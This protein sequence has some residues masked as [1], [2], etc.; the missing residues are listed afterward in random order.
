MLNS[1]RCLVV[2]LLGYRYKRYGFAWQSLFIKNMTKLISRLS[3][4]NELGCILFACI[5]YLSL[6][7]ARGEDSVSSKFQSYQED[8]GRIEVKALYLRAEK[9]LDE[10]TSLGVTALVDDITGATP[11]G[12]PAPVGSDQ[13]PLSTLTEHR[14][15]IIGDISRKWND[16]DTFGFEFAYSTESDYIS[17]GYS[18]RSNSEFNKKNTS[19]N[20][21]YSFID[22]DIAVGYQDDDEQ[23]FYS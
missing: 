5:I 1:S 21:G 8:D 19:L 11:S 9:D 23:K 17:R 15:A 7:K 6:P 2:F 13:V 14:K 22:D 3:F 10:L 18:L 20:L 16:R 12:Q 4:K